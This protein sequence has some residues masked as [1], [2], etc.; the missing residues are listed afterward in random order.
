[1]IHDFELFHVRV[2]L[3]TAAFQLRLIGVGNCGI[4]NVSTFK[5]S[6][7]IKMND[8]ASVLLI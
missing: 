1:M 8:S 4:W 2:V 6:R 5:S 3:K 7:V